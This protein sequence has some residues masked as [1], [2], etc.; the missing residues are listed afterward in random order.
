MNRVS[1]LLNHLTPSSQQQSQPCS[2]QINYQDTSLH[3]KKLKILITSNFYPCTPRIYKYLKSQGHEVTLLKTTDKMSEYRS[4]LL[5]HLK[6]IR[7]DYDGILNAW[8]LKLDKTIFKLLP[9]LKIVSCISA[10]F[11]NVDIEYCK[12]N[13][14]KVTNISPALAETVADYV[15]GLIL[16]TCRNI[17]NSANILRNKGVKIAKDPQY[18]PAFG[19]ARKTKDLYTATVGIIGLGLCMFVYLQ[20]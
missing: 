10:G 9:N 8:T 1:K 12:N 14:I 13:N 20:I 17:V 6:N 15:V 7:N 16:V 19:F 11:N 4:I 2:Q 18:F 5:S 3:T